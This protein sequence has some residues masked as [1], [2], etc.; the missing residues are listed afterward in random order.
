[1]S[2][3]GQVC[4]LRC[5]RGEKCGRT[6]CS[7]A[8]GMAEELEMT[9]LI[10]SGEYSELPV[11]SKPVLVTTI[12]VTNLKAARANA[13]SLTLSCKPGVRMNIEN[14]IASLHQQLDA[15]F[16][17]EAAGDGAGEVVV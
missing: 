14:Y 13:A 3:N 16:G 1:M 17:L 11:K 8:A 5:Q 15:L 2:D 10:F 12:T 7:G 6:M 4:D 9:G